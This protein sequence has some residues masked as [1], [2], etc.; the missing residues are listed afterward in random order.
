MAPI[1]T[2]ALSTRLA[3]R[4]LELVDVASESGAERDIAEHV[5]GVLRAGGV[6]ARD[7]G[8]TCVLAGALHR[9][10]R[11]LVL[12][13]GHLDTVPA[14]D[15]WPGRIDGEHVVGLGASDMKGGVAV[16]LEL[17]LARAADASTAPAGASAALDVGYVLFGREELP[18]AQAAL[19]P[20]LERESS[21]RDADL[22]IVLEPTDNVVHAGCLGNID[23]T[24]T[25][26]GRAGHSARPWLADSAIDRALAGIGELHA[27]AVERETIEGLEFA[28]VA[29]ATTL[30]A[31]VA[32]NVI[33][34]TCTANVNFRYS[35]RL[36]TEQAEHDLRARCERHGELELLSNS[37]GARP[38]RG[39]A[40]YE[41]LLSCSARPAQ[42]KQAWTPVAELAAAGI[43]AVNCGPGDPA[44][45][46]SRDERVASHALARSY[47]LLS[48]FLD[49]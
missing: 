7:G 44:H 5:L 40:L 45:A 11:P 6:D 37:P 21:L 49:G 27:H 14:Q 13:A 9:R 3:E 28:Q 31:G 8:D 29:T 48:A 25:F 23:A 17:A 16:M 12:L 41:R 43:E 30:H 19:A 38:P 47:E 4:T 32:R 36:S 18:S 35:P 46:H 22:A 10:K 34:G 2:P 15:N 24:W 33:P 1:S 39:N 20:L 42:A 26:T